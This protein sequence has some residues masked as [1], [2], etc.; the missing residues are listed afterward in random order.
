MTVIH[1]PNF[2]EDG[3]VTV[4]LDERIHGFQIEGGIVRSKTFFL[5][6]S[7]KGAQAGHARGKSDGEHTNA[8]NEMAAAEGSGFIRGRHLVGD[9]CVFFVHVTPPPSFGRRA[10]RHEV[11]PP[12]IRN[13]I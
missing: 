4:N 1:L 11:L 10:G 9:C 8:L 7:E 6:G 3:P 12:E 2:D 13:G 5:C